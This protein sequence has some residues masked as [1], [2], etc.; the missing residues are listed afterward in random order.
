[1]RKAFTLIELLIAITILSIM[2]LFLYKSYASLNRSNS[3]YKK[4][5]TSLKHETL[6]KKVI[7]L[8]FSLAVN[9]S[10]SILNQGKKEDI[11]LMQSSHSLHKRYNP[12][13]AYIMK[14]SE[15]YRLESLKR[16]TYPLGVGSEFSVDYIGE[17]DGFRT[18][19]SSKEIEDVFLVH[20]NF[21]NEDDIL[22]KIK[23]LEG[24]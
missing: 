8:D 24:S 5:V 23:V 10:I 16:L 17:V 19:T 18:Y 14:N 21:K 3:F 13:I 9:N 6:I 4:E 7:F 20:V 1:M 22:L 12:Y 15:L 11:V 2:M